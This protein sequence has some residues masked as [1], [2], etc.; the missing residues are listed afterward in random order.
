MELKSQYRKEHKSKGMELLS[1]RFNLLSREYGAEIQ[2]SVIDLESNTGPQGTLVKI[3][4]PISLSEKTK[5]A[6]H[7]THNYN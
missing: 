5:V 1:K 4:V 6:L 2:T 7:D 3:I